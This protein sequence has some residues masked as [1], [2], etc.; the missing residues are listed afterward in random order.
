MLYADLGYWIAHVH[1]RTKKP[2]R[3]AYKEWGKG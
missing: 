2:L 1:S 3:R